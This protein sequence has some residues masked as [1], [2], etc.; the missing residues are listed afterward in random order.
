[1]YWIDFHYRQLMTLLR[2]TWAH[3]ERWLSSACRLAWECACQLSSCV[4]HWGNSCWVKINLLRL[5]VN[6]W[7]SNGLHWWLQQLRGRREREKGERSHLRREE[8]DTR[9]EWNICRVSV[10]DSKGL[11]CSQTAFT[12]LIPFGGDSETKCTHI[13]RVNVF[14]VERRERKIYLSINSS[15]LCLRSAVHWKRNV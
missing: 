1:M 8:G 9:C 15:T 7:T 2:E 12:Q 10:A 3:R 5:I 4:S 6:N 11:R 13:T 14:K